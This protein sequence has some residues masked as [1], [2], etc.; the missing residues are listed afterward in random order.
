MR[1]RQMPSV[2]LI[3]LGSMLL[4]GC[5]PWT[6]TKTVEHEREISNGEAREMRKHSRAEVANRLG[7]PTS[8]DDHRMVYEWRMY[9]NNGTI[10]LC[11]Y[12]NESTRI[13][14]RSLTIEFDDHGYMTDW[15]FRNAG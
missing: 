5:I 6:Y 12:L 9:R 14:N 11:G 13:F 3:L 1:L 2:T 4:I 8:E 15:N 7:P 10:S